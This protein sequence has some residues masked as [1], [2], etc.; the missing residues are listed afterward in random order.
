MSMAISSS[1]RIRVSEGTLFRELQG[2]AVLLNLASESYFGLDEV[3]T[4][5]WTVLVSAESIHAAYE[6]LLVEYDVAPERLWADLEV[7]VGKLVE[8]GLVEI[9]GG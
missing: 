2:E 1:S 9:A 5:I 8:N 3:G 4:R 7:F 6:S